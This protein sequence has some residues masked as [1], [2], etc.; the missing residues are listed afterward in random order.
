MCLCSHRKTFINI[1]LSVQIYFQETIFIESHSA[2][3]KFSRTNIFLHAVILT[4][5]DEISR[6]TYRDY[7]PYALSFFSIIYDTNEV[8]VRVVRF[9]FFLVKN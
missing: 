4:T 5:V 6:L 8:K 7:G 3:L 1:V 2:E 9:Q